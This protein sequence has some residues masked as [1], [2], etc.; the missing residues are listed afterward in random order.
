MTSAGRTGRDGAGGEASP[1]AGSP[2]GDGE[3]APSALRSAL[4]DFKTALDE[5]WSYRHANRADFDG[6]IA[7][8]R[9]KLDGG[10]STDAFGLELQKV[11]ALGIDGHA[12]VSGYRVPGGRYLPFLIEPAGER[13]VAFDAQRTAFLVDGFPYLTA[14][15]GRDLADWCRAVAALVPKGSPAYVRHRCLGLLR[16]L[17]MVRELLALPKTDTL[18]VALASGAGGARTTL[19]LRVATSPPA[20]GAWPRG[21]SRLLNGGVGY[22]RLAFM[23]KA[24]SVGEIA[25]WMPL[26]RGTTG[27]VVDVRDN[28]G[29]D[30]DAL[31]LLY[32][33]LAAP[34]DAPRVCNAAVYRLHAAH[35][36][37]HLA[38][39]HFMYRADAEE[40]NPEERRAIAA[41][42]GTFRPGWEPPA[43]QFSAWHY[44]VLSRREGPGVYHYERPVVVLM[45][46][47]CFSATDIFLA[48]LK[49]MKNVTL[50]GTPSSGGSAGTREVGL[51]GTPLRVRLGTMVSFQADGRLFDGN[52]VRPDVPVEPTPEYHIGGADTVLAEA[53]NRVRKPTADDDAVDG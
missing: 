3:F 10:M 6:A 39:A 22:L 32:S 34:G 44:M 11:V 46:G 17:D 43:G 35:R 29:G 42:A 14:I 45:N 21:G 18:E 51:G 47:K 23:D 15:D 4:D 9:E 24:S 52:G 38:G 7:A 31:R 13:F 36:E 49:G 20:Y 25:R 30:R 28:D 48:G 2:A 19:T 37:D 8:L 27:L 53:V 50:L 16:N 40:W 26:F 12:R 41:F 5:R 1:E 33:Y